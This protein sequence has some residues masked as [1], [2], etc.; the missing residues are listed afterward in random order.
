M[1]AATLAAIAWIE[2]MPP[3]VSR[4]QVTTQLAAM[5]TISG[6]DDERAAGSGRSTG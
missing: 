1:G 5:D 3:N 6:A 2:E 4:E